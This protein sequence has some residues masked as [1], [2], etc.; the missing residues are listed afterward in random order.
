MS[1]EEQNTR[2]KFWNIGKMI[3]YLR[4][5]Q[6]IS[7]ECLSQG[8]CS[9]AT[10]SR[11]ENS[12][13]FCSIL[14]AQRL[15]GR[16]GWKVCDFESY[17][18]DKEFDWYEK[19]MEI[20]E[21]KKQKNLVQMK[22][23]VKQYE[24]EIGKKR[25]D[26]LQKQ[27]IIAEEAFFMIEEKKL[28][29]G[30]LLIKE[31]ISLTINGWEE[32]DVFL[33]GFEELELFCM[34]ADAYEKLEERELAYWIWKRMLNYLEQRK[35]KKK[36]IAEPYTYIISRIVPYLLNCKMAKKGMELCE[37]GIQTAADTLNQNFCCELLYWKAKCIRDLYQHGK[38]KGVEA[39]QNYQFAYYLCI[40]FG[41]TELA[42]EIEGYLKEEILDGYLSN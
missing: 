24:K 8:I 36:Q 6:Q 41:K 28:E 17:C 25:E 11:I 21:L 38:I 27:F 37:K 7:L 16:L 12:E 23:R 32:N 9:I 1:Q 33:L 39:I 15:L 34:L 2:K 10:L 30:V 22:K 3:R 4:E 31:A 20:L 35:I 29:E 14:L 26:P 13:R 5:E 18:S 19:R 42:Q 40:S